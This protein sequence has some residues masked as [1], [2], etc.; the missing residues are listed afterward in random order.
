MELVHRHVRP[1]LP[2]FQRHRAVPAQASCRGPH[3]HV[4]AGGRG[5]VVPLLLAILFI[6]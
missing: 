3:G 6:H 2:D 4:A 1:G 5:L